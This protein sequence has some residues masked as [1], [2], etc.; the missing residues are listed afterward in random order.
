MICRSLPYL[1]PT[2]DPHDTS[3]HAAKFLSSIKS[4][5]KA[6]SCHYRILRKTSGIFAGSDE[7]EKEKLWTTAVKTVGND[8]GIN[9]TGRA[10]S[11]Y[12]RNTRADNWPFV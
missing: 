9:H 8:W 11:E 3:S 10:R 4:R 1:L 6:G 5:L 12:E 2:D 7:A